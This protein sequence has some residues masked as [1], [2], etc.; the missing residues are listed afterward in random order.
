MI[1]DN[2]N[3]CPVPSLGTSPLRG[4]TQDAG[5]MA[6]WV[7]FTASE[8]VQSLGGWRAGGRQV[9]L[10]DLQLGTQAF[11]VKI[12]SW[13]A[14]LPSSETSNESSPSDLFSG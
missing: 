11:L 4:W 13:D 7:P 6:G 3:F 9:G 12:F 1:S 10:P 8:V 2:T 14:F 5:G